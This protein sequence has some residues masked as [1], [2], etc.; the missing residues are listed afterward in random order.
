MTGTVRVTDVPEQ[1]VRVILV[2]PFPAL[3][4]SPGEMAVATP[5]EGLDEFIVST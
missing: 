5:L 2:V 3:L 4:T 1:Y